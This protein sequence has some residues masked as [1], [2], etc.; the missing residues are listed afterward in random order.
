LLLRPESLL[1][2][3]FQMSFAAAV[4]LVAAYEVAAPHL[5]SRASG[6]SVTRRLL[7]YLAAVAFSTVIAS[8]ATAP[9]AIFHFN[10]LAALG[11]VANMAAVPIAAFWVMPLEVLALV[12]MPFGLDGL[13]MP[14]L[15]AGVKA[16]LSVA[17]A[18][19]G[20]TWAAVPVPAM[21]PW[22]LL[23]I[24]FGGLWLSLWRRRWRFSGLVVNAAGLATVGSAPV[25]DILVSERNRIVALR[26]GEGIWRVSDT[27]AEPFVREMWARRLAI[28]GFLPFPMPGEAV[29]GLRCD[30]AGCVSKTGGHTVAIVSD[31]LALSEDCRTAD[32]VIA[33]VPAPRWC[34][35]PVRVLDFFDMWR[36]GAHAVWL[37]DGGIP[38]IWRARGRDP[39]RPW[40]R[41]ETR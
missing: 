18:V 8:L 38:A 6:M 19:S 31:A 11:L 30:I 35:G 17:A 10:R 21:T 23:A 29:A 3:S 33:T 2:A 25:P 12:L 9:F 5:R 36:S 39:A 32:I 4:A 22:G 16:I 24:V 37:T 40:Q 27:R 26:D 13:V 14:L 34:S 15:G 20:W 41:G 28:E 7:L 1:S